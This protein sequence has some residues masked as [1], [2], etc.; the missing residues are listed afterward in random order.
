MRRGKA[1]PVLLHNTDLFGFEVRQQRFN[2][3]APLAAAGAID[4]AAIRR[5]PKSQQPNPSCVFPPAAAKTRR[6][7]VA[8]CAPEHTVVI[9]NFKYLARADISEFE[10]YHPS[11]AVGLCRWEGRPF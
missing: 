5:Q 6:V 3:V 7:S 9:T 11:H 1:R 4:F 2:S 8:A 10:S